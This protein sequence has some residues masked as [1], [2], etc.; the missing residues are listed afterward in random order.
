M[1]GQWAGTKFRFMEKSPIRPTDDDARALA[2]SLMSDATH[3][4]LGVIDPKTNAPFVSRIALMLGP[5]QM[6]ISLV[7]SL[8][9]HTTAL[10][11]NPTCSLLIGS[12]PDKGEPLA[13]PRLTLSARAEFIPHEK[14]ADLRQ[15]YA[16]NAP[17]SKLYLGFAD[18][19]FVVF[20]PNG[21]SLNGGFGKAYALTPA[22]LRPS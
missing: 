22:D 20:H 2:Q 14:D 5:E 1:Q 9:F 10:L 3:A 6:P 13:F 19:S 16:R 21:A 12:P 15:H 11:Q 8:A 18:F 7:S 17:K 4:A